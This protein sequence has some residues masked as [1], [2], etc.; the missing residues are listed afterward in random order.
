MKLA[1]VAKIAAALMSI[2]SMFL[3]AA[4][5][6]GM[7]GVARS[8]GPTI[9][10]GIPT[11]LPYLSL[12]EGNKYS[13]FDI[14]VAEYVADKLG[15]SYK[16]IIWKQV[17]AGQSVSDLNNGVVGMII[18]DY[19]ISAA[20]KQNVDFAG[21]Y[22]VQSQK[23]LVSAKDNSINSLQDLKGKSVCVTAGSV[24]QRVIEGALGASVSVH[25]LPSAPQC[26]TELFDG[27]VQA[28]SAGGVLLSA[29]NKFKGGGYLKV[30]GN[31]FATEYM[32]IAVRKDSPD[33]VYQINQDIKLMMTSGTWEKDLKATVGQTGYKI[34]SFNM[35]SAISAQDSQ[36]TASEGTGKND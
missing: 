7:G 18:G 21:P 11:D 14:D 35:P 27:S 10:I 24:S 13:G 6:N 25:S 19:P 31:G 5:G 29:L 1:K 23:L 32:G 17:P 33:F 8:T 3:L 4:C 2:G 16:Q 26:V 9:T 22:L 30:V 34:T 28:V 36:E 12:R 20:S 15:Y